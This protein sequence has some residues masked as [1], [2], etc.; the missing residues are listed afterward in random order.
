MWTGCVLWFESVIWDNYL[1]NFQQRDKASCLDHPSKVWQT[2]WKNGFIKGWI[3]QGCHYFFQVLRALKLLCEYLKTLYFIILNAWD[4]L[5]RIQRTLM[6]FD[7]SYSIYLL[8]WKN[9]LVWANLIYNEEVSALQ[10]HLMCVSSHNCLG[11]TLGSCWNTPLTS[12][13]K[14]RVL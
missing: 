7:L 2:M 6:S 12:K 5:E 14:E 8:W 13:V 1:F 9:F 4:V 10:V 11:P 3:L